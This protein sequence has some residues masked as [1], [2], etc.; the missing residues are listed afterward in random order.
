MRSLAGLA[1]AVVILTAGWAPLLAQEG[2]SVPVCRSAQELAI[3]GTVESVRQH[4]GWMG[5]DGL[6]VTLR[7]SD[8]TYEVHLAPASFLADLGMSI[9][10]GDVIEVKGCLARVDSED[11]LVVR[12]IRKRNVV[13]NLRDQKGRPVW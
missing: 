7:G 11:V 9:E 10:R 3:P 8:R 4:A 13:L 5:W 1:A 12:E 6:Y 2:A